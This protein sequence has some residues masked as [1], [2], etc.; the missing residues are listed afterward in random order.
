M[1][2]EEMDAILEPRLQLHESVEIYYIV[3]DWSAKLTSR[4][5]DHVVAE[6]YGRTPMTALEALCEELKTTPAQPGAGGR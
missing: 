4:D 6:A 5:G 3:T 1:T 2:K